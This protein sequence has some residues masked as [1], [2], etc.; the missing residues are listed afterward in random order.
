[1][2]FGCDFGMMFIICG[3]GKGGIL[4]GGMVFKDGKYDLVM[5]CFIESDWNDKEY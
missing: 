5:D 3:D 1:M 4:F 2:N